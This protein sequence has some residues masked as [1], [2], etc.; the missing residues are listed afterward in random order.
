MGNPIAKQRGLAEHDR[1]H[2]L[3]ITN[4]NQV[5]R[6]YCIYSNVVSTIAIIGIPIFIAYIFN[7]YKNSIVNTPSGVVLYLVTVFCIALFGYT[8]DQFLK[9]YLFTKAEMEYI[10]ELPDKLLRCDL[11]ASEKRFKSNFGDS[12]YV[13]DQLFQNSS[14]EVVIV[15]TKTR[16]KLKVLRS[17]VEQLARYSLELEIS[18]GAPISSI[19]YIRCVT[20]SVTRYLP[21]K[22]KQ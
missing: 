7:P 13:P 17:D 8:I 12:T 10:N 3:V 2:S 4:H 18:L 21:V 9:K 11:L 16:S 6:R 1:F 22:F 15:D 5:R 14:F 19:G 20:P